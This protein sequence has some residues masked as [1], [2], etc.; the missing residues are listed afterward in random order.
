MLIMDGI[1]VPTRDH[2]IAERSKNHRH[3]PN[4]QVVIDA[5]TRRVVVVGRPLAGNRNDC[6]AWEEPGAKTAVGKTL[7]IADGGHPGTGLVIPHRPACGGLGPPTPPRYRTPPRAVRALAEETGPEQFTE[8]T[9]RQGSKGPTTSRFTALTIR[10]AG[11]Q[12]LAAAQ[13]AG[14]GR[15]RWDGILPARTLLIEWPHGQGT[16][17]GYWTS[18]LPATTP[19]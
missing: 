8:V 3:S 11:K 1:L 15:N 12:S 17:T 6:K 16:P 19:R 7:T 10:P 4:H 13:N 5:D 14:G 2:A 18:N 9:W